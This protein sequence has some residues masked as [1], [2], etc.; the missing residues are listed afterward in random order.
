MHGYFSL[1]IAE[2]KQFYFNIHYHKYHIVVKH[3]K[4]FTLIEFNSTRI[5]DISIIIKEIN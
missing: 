2:G 4:I 3:P 5:F 1:D